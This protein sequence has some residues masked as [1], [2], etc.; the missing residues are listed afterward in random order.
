MPPA[1]PPDT[2]VDLAFGHV[3]RAIRT[4]RG[5]SQEAVGLASGAGR[6]FVSQLERG[7][8]GASLKTLFR[9]AQ[10]LGVPPGEIVT[11]VE[12]EVAALGRRPR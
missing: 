1:R 10:C 5:L 7:E 11:R 12:V 8:R 6:T 3:L 4:E 2:G 9:L